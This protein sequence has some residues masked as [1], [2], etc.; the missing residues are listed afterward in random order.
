[1]KKSIFWKEF[2]IFYFPSQAGFHGPATPMGFR[3]HENRSSRLPNS[4][5]ALARKKARGGSKINGTKTAGVDKI[6]LRQFSIEKNVKNFV[7]CLLIINHGCVGWC[8][9][10][11]HTKWMTLIVEVESGEVSQWIRTCRPRSKSTKIR[12]QITQ[13]TSFSVSQMPWTKLALR[14]LPKIFFSKSKSEGS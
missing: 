14:F 5:W 12:Y 8:G 2:W 4:E 7:K 6:R 10:E 1:M 9:W 13:V 3:K 11:S